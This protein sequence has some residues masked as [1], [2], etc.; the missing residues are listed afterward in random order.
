[1]KKVLILFLLS[2]TFILSSNFKSNASHYTNFEQITMTKGK[3]LN[4]FTSTELKNHQKKVNSRKFMGWRTHTVNNRVKI[5]YIS[6]TIF[7]YYNDGYTPFDYHY[8]LEETNTKKYSVST[9]GSIGFSNTKSAT[10]FKNGLDGSLKI[11]FKSENTNQKKETYDI[12][13]KVDPGTRVD[14]YIYGEGRITNG[15]AA[16]Y[17]FWIRSNSGGFEYF[18]MTTSYQ[19][20][21]KVK[22]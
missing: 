6:E 16:N 3:L 18:E 4:D 19:R 22:I 11:D 14:L 13:L 7:S 5:S 10:G 15:V 9:T 2:S 21:E 1:M 12:K 20:L 8:K 17:F